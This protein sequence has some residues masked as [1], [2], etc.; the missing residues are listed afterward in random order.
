MMSAHTATS[1]STPA[2]IIFTSQGPPDVRLNVLSQ[3]YHVHSVV[4]KLHSAYFWKFLDS[5][6][7]TDDPPTGTAF[8]YEWVTKVDEEDKSGWQL[9]CA[10]PKVKDQ[11]D[12]SI[13]IHAN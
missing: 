2:P 3:E 9:V 12:Q 11:F 8:K 1:V 4:L 13:T 7:K 5:P 6:D 10:G